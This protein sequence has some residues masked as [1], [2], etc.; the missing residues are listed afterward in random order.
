VLALSAAIIFRAIDDPFL[1]T[2]G[3]AVFRPSQAVKAFGLLPYQIGSYFNNE[4]SLEGLIAAMEPAGPTHNFPERYS[5]SDIVVIQVE[6]LG[7]DILGAR[8][9]GKAIMPYLER[10]TNESIFF[11][12]SLVYHKGGGTSDTEVP[13]IS[14][15]ETIANYPAA[16]LPLDYRNSFVKSLKAEGYSTV[17]YHGN[18]A[19]YFN[20]GTSFPAMGFDRF[21]S[22]ET[23]GIKSAGWGA[24]DQ[25][26]FS[27]IAEDIKVDHR[28]FL[29]YVITMSSHGPYTNV[30]KYYEAPFKQDGLSD[31]E[32]RYNTSMSY[33]DAELERAIANFKANGADYIIIFG[34]HPDYYVEGNDRSRERSTITFDGVKM[35]FTPLFIITPDGTTRHEKAKVA[36]L[37]DIG[38]TIL[39]ASGIPGSI[40]TWGEN[41]LESEGPVEPIIFNGRKYDRQ[42]LFNAVAAISGKAIE[43]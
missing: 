19:S 36:S 28:P 18:N 20:R 5:R 11:P 15:T 23:M 1:Y 39:S 27:F 10:L 26:V 6:S 31:I 30:P 14:S 8:S 16:N 34:D 3:R 22:L 2:I 4:R 42:T 25:E 17:I 35:K 13:V 33:V 9:D 29:R 7:T 21:E 32:A 41:L 24:P 12:Y 37:L 40:I 43:R 38:P